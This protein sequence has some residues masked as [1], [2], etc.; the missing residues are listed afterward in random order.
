[1]VTTVVQLIHNVVLTTGAAGAL[2]TAAVATTAVASVF[3][4]NPER[5]R[6]AHETLKILLRQCPR[7][8]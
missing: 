1:M 3:A 2:Y 6:D 4:R 7:R 8:C 5:R